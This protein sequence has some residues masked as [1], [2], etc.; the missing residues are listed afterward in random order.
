MGR[1]A[2]VNQYSRTAPAIALVVTA[3]TAVMAGC[4]GGPRHAAAAGPVT[5]AVSPSRPLQVTVPGVATVTGPRGAFRGRGKVTVRPVQAQLPFGNSLTAAGTGI[6][7]TFSGVTLSRALTISFDTVGKRSMLVL[8]ATQSKSARCA[9]SM[10]NGR[11][12]AYA[13]AGGRV[14]LLIQ[15]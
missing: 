7:V 5:V 15:R 2:R 12:A 8:S 6:D 3:A 9:G 4:D 13:R 14:A 11:P 1:G 10:A